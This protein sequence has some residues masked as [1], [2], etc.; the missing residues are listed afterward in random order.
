PSSSA[1]A[2]S[3]SSTRSAAARVP[4]WWWPAPSASVNW[5]R[6][7]RPSRTSA[8]PS[9]RPARPSTHAGPH[10]PPLSHKAA[11]APRTPA[12][13]PAGGDGE[14]LRR[15]RPDDPGRLAFLLYPAVAGTA[16]GAAAVADRLAVP[17]GAAVAG[18]PDRRAG[19]R[20]GRGGGGHGDP[21]C[22]CAAGRRL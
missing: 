13:K 7:N 18:E 20:T 8:A 1:P 19:R 11:P 21:Q 2:T 4:R 22:R 6:P 9:P 10:D 5:R 16:A 17:A 14:A 3:A 12:G 15:G